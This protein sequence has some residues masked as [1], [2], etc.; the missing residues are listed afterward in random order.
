MNNYYKL[1]FN[2]FF[3]SNFSSLIFCILLHTTK[4]S[5]FTLATFTLEIAG[6]LFGCEVIFN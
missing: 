2:L 3:S 5:E 6:V 4:I 1:K